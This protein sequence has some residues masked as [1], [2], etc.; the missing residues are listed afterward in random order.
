[1]IAVS[2]RKAR[3][4]VNPQLMG[5]VFI[6][7]E[8]RSGTKLLRNTLNR[9]PE[10][11]ILPCETNFLPFFIQKYGE[12]P[13]FDD[14]V[15]Y[16]RFYAEFLN[17]E[18]SRWYREFLKTKYTMPYSVLEAVPDKRSWQDVFSA[19]ALA[20]IYFH[21]PPDIKVWGDKSP[22]YTY[23]TDLLYDLFPQSK[24]V[25]IVRDPRAVSLSHQASFGTSMY[26][27]ADHWATALQ[28]IADAR[29]RYRPDRYLEIRFEDLVQQP[30][31][32]LTTVC[33]FLNRQFDP[34]MLEIIH[35]ENLGSA[36][37]KTVIVSSNVQ[38]YSKLAPNQVKR[39]EEITFP[40]AEAYGYVPEYATRHQ[41][42]SRAAMAA[43]TLADYAQNLA[44]YARS[45]GLKGVRHVINQKRLTSV[46]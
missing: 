6:I 40:T 42:L 21:S 13:P 14:E 34:A 30:E 38:S 23:H 24:L 16:R 39:I 2:G 32:T 46:K 33:Q 43:L 22:H 27:A 5:P 17:T 1:M 44:R 3:L 28:A 10:I 19:V 35:P 4:L 26:R 25:H 36:R 7:G 41:P 20:H 12:A 15:T 8:K 37:G 11:A 45:K 29:A 9:N 18:F 31:D